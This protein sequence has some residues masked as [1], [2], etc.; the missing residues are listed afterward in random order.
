[1][2]CVAPPLVTTRQQIDKIVAIL[3]EVVPEAI[4]ATA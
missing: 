4:R 3:A 2:I 1:M